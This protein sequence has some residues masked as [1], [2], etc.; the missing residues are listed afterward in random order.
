VE[1]Q[2]I[3]VDDEWVKISFI[4][5]KDKKSINISKTTIIRIENILN[6]GIIT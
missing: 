5:K 4:D 3:D 6:I 1:C 2:I